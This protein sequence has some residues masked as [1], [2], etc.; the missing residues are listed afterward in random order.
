MMRLRAVS[1]ITLAVLTL[2]LI[3]LVPES[4]PIGPLRLVARYL[5]VAYVPGLVIWN[6]LKSGR[7]SLID[8]VLYPSLLAVLPFAWLTLA[9][10]AVGVDLR[11]AI[12]IAVLAFL[13]IGFWL[14]WSDKVRG[15]SDE[16]IALGVAVALTLVLLIAPFAANSF[17]AVAWDAPVHASIVSRVLNGIVPPGSPMMAG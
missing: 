5:L 7:P 4:V 9:I 2:I 10:L 14:G 12:W 3:A 15:A 17:Q 8:I 1:G 16:Y 11:L 13:A 6:R